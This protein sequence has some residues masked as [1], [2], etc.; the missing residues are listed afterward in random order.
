MGAEDNPLSFVLTI[1]IVLSLE[2]VGTGSQSTKR[3]A[4][5]TRGRGLLALLILVAGLLV[6]LEAEDF[7]GRLCL[8]RA[9][10]LLFLG[11]IYSSLF[12]GGDASFVLFYTRCSM[13]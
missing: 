3:K 7:T 6:L 11:A 12:V 13:F 5:A 9:C 4:P 10:P 8:S 1:A 2:F